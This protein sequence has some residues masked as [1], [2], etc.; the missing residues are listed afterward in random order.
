MN[1]IVLRV[2]V[3]GV[4]AGVV[5]WICRILQVP[6]VQIGLL[7]SWGLGCMLFSYELGGCRRV[8]RQGFEERSWLERAWLAAGALCLVGAFGV[9]VVYF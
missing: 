3:I 8:M 5:G 1:T 9:I 7:A 4:F 6:A 2:L